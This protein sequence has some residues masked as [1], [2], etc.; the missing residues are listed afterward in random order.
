MADAESLG[1]HRELN[2]QRQAV[3]AAVEIRSGKF[4]KISFNVLRDQH[5]TRKSCNWR[6]TACPIDR[7][8]T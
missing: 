1:F 2:L 8:S 7:R 4:Y 3:R 6:Y 5:A